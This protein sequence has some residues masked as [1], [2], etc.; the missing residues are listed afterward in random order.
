[1]SVVEDHGAGSTET[2][3]TELTQTSPRD[4]VGPRFGK[5]HTVVG[6]AARDAQRADSSCEVCRASCTERCALLLPLLAA[7]VL[8]DRGECVRRGAISRGDGKVAGTTAQAVPPAELLPDLPQRPLLWW[9]SIQ[10]HAPS[11]S[12][13]QA[14]YRDAGVR[15]LE[16]DDSPHMS[17]AKEGHAVDALQE[18]RSIAASPRR[19]AAALESKMQLGVAPAYDDDQVLERKVF[20]KVRTELANCSTDTSPKDDA[21]PLIDRG[22]RSALL[23]PLLPGPPL[24]SL[25]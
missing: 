11:P 25:L 4:E 8:L 5:G 14:A 13:P 15:S 6:R 19:G 1:M 17:V 7:S 3:L 10:V 2:M 12:P 24:W 22:Q 9:P 16:V 23:L 21:D 18:S 20:D